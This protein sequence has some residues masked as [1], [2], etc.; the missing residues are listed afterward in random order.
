MRGG[1]ITLIDYALLA[2]NSMGMVGLLLGSIG[3][4]NTVSLMLFK[5]IGKDLIGLRDTARI[6]IGKSEVVVKFGS[7]RVRL[8]F[9]P[10]NYV[11]KYNA[12]SEASEH[13]VRGHYNVD[14]EGK[15]VVDIG[16]S[17]GDTLVYF[18]KK[19]ARRA[20]GFEPYP[21]AYGYARENV[22]ANGVEDR[23]TLINEACTGRRGWITLDEKRKSTVDDELIASKN[24]KRIRLCRLCD[25]VQRFG[26][27]EGGIL[28]IDAEQSEYE[29]IIGSSA[30]TLRKFDVIY[31][32]YHNGYLNL[33]KKLRSAGFEVE[34]T[35][36]AIIYDA[37]AKRRFLYFGDIVA[38]KLPLRRTA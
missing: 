17:I 25:I 10:S 38:K 14:V 26:I 24:G 33:E 16:A 11:S 3:V 37:I 31:V 2:P 34:H 7:E 36:P 18:L 8:K 5:L 15:T 29:I 27:H 4:F 1:N 32:E 12:F 19:G 23:A 28:K 30:E 22:M 9:D 20:Y 13:F 35:G 6:S 21:Y